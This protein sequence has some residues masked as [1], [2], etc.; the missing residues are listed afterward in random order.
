MPHDLPILP[1]KHQ[2]KR[3]AVVPVCEHGMPAKEVR[4]V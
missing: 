2:K 4:G 3:R 1:I